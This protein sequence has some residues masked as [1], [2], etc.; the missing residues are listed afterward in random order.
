MAKSNPR[1]RK[2]KRARTLAISTLY[3][4]CRED[5]DGQNNFYVRVPY[6]RISG[7][8]LQQA[9]FYINNRVRVELKRRGRL[10]LT[11]V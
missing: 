2:P 8:W 7:A 10:V 1:T 6:I 11:Q 3:N 9:G 4:H 5:K